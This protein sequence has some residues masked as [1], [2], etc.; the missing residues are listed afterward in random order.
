[1]KGEKE[2]F[3]SVDQSACEACNSHACHV[4]GVCES[5]KRSM[6][7]LLLVHSH[8]HGQPGR[9]SSVSSSHSKVSASII[10]RIPRFIFFIRNM[11]H[12][13]EHSSTSILYASATIISNVVRITSNGLCRDYASISSLKIH[14]H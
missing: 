14:L 2:S 11:L 12:L 5:P 9:W 1:M 8:T 10:K 13:I 7:P 3:R 4:T 6:P